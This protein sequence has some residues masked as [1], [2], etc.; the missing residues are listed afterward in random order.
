MAFSKN[1]PKTSDK[2]V[3]PKWVEITLTEEEEK[4][5]EVKARK[6]HVHA[7]RQ[8]IEDARLIVQDKRLLESQNQLVEIAKA[9]F[10]KRASHEVFFKEEK[11]KEKFDNL[12][13]D[14]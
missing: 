14:S 10:D 12:H 6:K 9:L 13:Q 2:S 3:Y 1:F 7:M 4:E 8:S 11:A 5:A